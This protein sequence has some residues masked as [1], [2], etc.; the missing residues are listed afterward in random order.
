MKNRPVAQ[1]QLVEWFWVCFFHFNLFRI[2]NDNVGDCWSRKKTHGRLYITSSNPSQ[3]VETWCNAS[4]FSFSIICPWTSKLSLSS[5]N[6]KNG[7]ETSGS[8]YIA[9]MALKHSYICC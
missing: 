1:I 8:M 7:H 2:G 9:P 6:A 5:T 3:I 4:K